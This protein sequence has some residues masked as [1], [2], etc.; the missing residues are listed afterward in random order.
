MTVDGGRS[1]GDEASIAL[2][3]EPDAAPGSVQIVLLLKMSGC[4]GP[5]KCPAIASSDY[6]ATLDQPERVLQKGNIYPLLREFT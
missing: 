6:R 1:A 3:Q 2:N 5:R 4:R